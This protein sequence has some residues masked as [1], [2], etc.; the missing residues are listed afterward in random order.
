MCV[1]DLS[2]AVDYEDVKALDLGIV[3]RNKAP[4]YR[5]GSSENSG[6]GQAGAGG[7]GGSGDSGGMG[8]GS[9]TYPVKI[10]VKNQPEG[11]KFDPRVKAISI[12]EG[13]HPI[14]INEIIAHYPANDGDT[15]KPAEKVR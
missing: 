4:P 8:G 5:L 6:G 3:V 2:Q 11:P 14:N 10:N 9:K 13:G 7:S 15:G 1:C 12:S